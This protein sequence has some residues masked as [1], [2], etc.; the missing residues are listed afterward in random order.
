MGYHR[1][2]NMYSVR[3]KFDKGDKK[4]KCATWETIFPVSTRLKDEYTNQQNTNCIFKCVDGEVKCNI[5]GLSCSDYFSES[6]ENYFFQGHSFPFLVDSQKYRASVIKI[7]VDLAYGFEVEDMNLET[8]LELMEFLCSNDKCKESDFERMILCLCCHALLDSN[9]QD[10]YFAYVMLIMISFEVDIVEKTVA[11]FAQRPFFKKSAL[12]LEIEKM[13]ATPTDGLHLKFGYFSRISGSITEWLQSF[14]IT[15]ID[16]IEGTEDGEK[17]KIEEF[18]PPALPPVTP[19]PS[20]TE[21]VTLPVKPTEENVAKGTE[22]SVKEVPQKKLPDNKN[23]PKSKKKKNKS[24]KSKTE[25]KA[26]QVKSPKTEVIEPSKK[27][28]EKSNVQIDK[29]INIAKE[30]TVK[31]SVQNKDDSTEETEDIPITILKAKFPGGAELPDRLQ[32]LEGQL[33]SNSDIKLETDKHAII[34]KTLEKAEKASNSSSSSSSDSSANEEEVK[35]EGTNEEKRS[36]KQTK[37][38]KTKKWER[39]MTKVIEP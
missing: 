16:T 6:I 3:I 9:I 8:I 10:D 34:K 38:K 26:L 13:R 33:Q 14:D 19:P 2:E 25:Q 39:M 12:K 31:K 23:K 32:K 20:E 29:N 35:S 15:R 24:K 30:V 18:V 11:K 17:A 5:F 37:S 1:D 28:E 22:D 27:P 36:K 4:C 7:F 21:E